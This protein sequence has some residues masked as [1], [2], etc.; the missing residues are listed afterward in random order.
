MGIFPLD[1]KW[2]F[3]YNHNHKLAIILLTRGYTKRYARK[4]AVY[5]GIVAALGN[6]EKA[7]FFIMFLV[8]GYSTTVSIRPCQG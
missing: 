6:N 2:F 8:C 3:L 1:K 5:S 4:L 7:S